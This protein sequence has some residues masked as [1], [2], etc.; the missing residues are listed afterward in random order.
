MKTESLDVMNNFVGKSG[1]SAEKGKIGEN[2]V[3]QP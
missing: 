3:F 2:W 1:S